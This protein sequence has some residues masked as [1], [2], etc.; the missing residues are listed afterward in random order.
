[1]VLPSYSNLMIKRL[2]D[3]DLPGRRLFL[4]SPM[5]ILR[6]R[7]SRYIVR[8]SVGSN[9]YGDD[10]LQHTPQSQSYYGKASILIILSMIVCIVP[11]VILADRFGRDIYHITQEYYAII[12]KEDLF[13]RQ[14]YAIPDDYLSYGDAALGDDSDIFGYFDCT[15]DDVLESYY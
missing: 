11:I 12:A 14:K 15:D 9:S 5:S 2:H 13:C 3:I 1:M 10:P 7:I 8:G 6:L 4:P